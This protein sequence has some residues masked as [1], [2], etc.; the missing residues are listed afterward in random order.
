M[1]EADLILLTERSASSPTPKLLA[2]EKRVSPFTTLYFWIGA[3][4][5]LASPASPGII[6]FVPARSL[7]GLSMELALAI[8]SAATP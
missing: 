4:A 1:T 5:E 2:I 6:S 3:G 7:D 8:A